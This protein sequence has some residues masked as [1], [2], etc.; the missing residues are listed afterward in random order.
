MDCELVAEVGVPLFEW[1]LSVWC[2]DRVSVP[3]SSDQI[4][5]ISEMNIQAM[6]AKK[7]IGA[8]K[9]SEKTSQT[10]SVKKAVV[11]SVFPS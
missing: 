2:S 11:L 10:A 5:T 8:R 7:A 1:M 3:S 4:R 9:T 6:K